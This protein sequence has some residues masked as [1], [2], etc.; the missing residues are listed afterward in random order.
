[1]LVVHVVHTRVVF[2]FHLIHCRCFN[3]NDNNVIIDL[4]CNS[5]VIYNRMM[6]NYSKPKREMIKKYIVECSSSA[7]N[8]HIIS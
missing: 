3:I 2:M 8:S 4:P 7:V 1:M 6:N 5:S